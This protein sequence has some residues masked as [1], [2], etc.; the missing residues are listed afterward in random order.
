MRVAVGAVAAPRVGWQPP[1]D[2]PDVPSARCTAEYG[3]SLEREQRTHH[4]GCYDDGGKQDNM[5]KVLCAGGSCSAGECLRACFKQGPDLSSTQG[6]AWRKGELWGS[7]VWNS[8]GGGCF[9]AGAVQLPVAGDAGVAC[10]FEVL[11]IPLGCLFTG[12]QSCIDA[13]GGP[14]GCVWT[15]DAC[16]VD[17]NGI[18]LSGPSLRE[19]VPWWAWGVGALLLLASSLLGLLLRSRSSRALRRDGYQPALGG[20]DDIQTAIA[21]SLLDRAEAQRQYEAFLRELADEEAAST[22]GAATRGSDGLSAAA[23]PALATPGPQLPAPAAEA[24]SPQSLGLESA[25]AEAALLSPE[26][27]VE[28]AA[29][30]AALL[31]PEQGPSPPPPRGAAAPVSEGTATGDMCPV[32][33][34]PLRRGAGGDSGARAVTLRCAHRACLPCMLQIARHEVAQGRAPSCPLCRRVVVIDEEAAP[35]AP[36]HC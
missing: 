14:G 17:A 22:G 2:G 13:P 29:A 7:A 19:L 5:T 8:T 30:E 10:A 3:S 1:E 9:C 15:E 32:C 25:A 21:R 6:S 11:N 18:D 4:K 33:F 34:E 36:P 12:R 35:D 26:Q 27:R 20:D 31:S 24:V 28:P 23:D 16:C